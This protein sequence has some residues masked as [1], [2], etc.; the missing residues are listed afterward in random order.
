MKNT[1]FHVA[2]ICA[3]LLCSG[4]SNAAEIRVPADYP[5]IQSAIDNAIHGDK[6]K[7]VYG[8]Y[9]E[10]LRLADAKTVDLSCGWDPE[11]ANDGGK[12]TIF[13][14][15]ELNSGTM[16]VDS[17]TISKPLTTP[18][19]VLMVATDTDKVQMASPFKAELSFNS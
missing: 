4:L 11:Y 5:T 17:L 6:I 16:V 12:S 18:T 7:I 14:A 1:G 2:F 9:G 3:A 8:S 15:L 13:G 19:L 10:Y